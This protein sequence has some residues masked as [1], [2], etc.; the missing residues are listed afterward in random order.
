MAQ[1]VVPRGRTGRAVGVWWLAL[2]A[3]AF[4]V[5]APLPYLTDGLQAMASGDGGLAAHYAAQPTWVQVVL[6]VHMICSGTALLLSPVQL[7]SRVRRRTP[8]THRVVGR[9]TFGALVGGG[10]AGALL[11]PFSVAGALGTAGFGLLAVLSVVFP[12]LGL[13]SALRGDLAQHRRWMIR[14]F[15]LIYAGVMLRLGLIVVVASTGWDFDRAYLLMPFGSWV[16]NLLVAEFVLWRSS[17]RRAAR[18][19]RG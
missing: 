11:A 8:R 6:Y 16:P 15:A 19:P 2:T 9:I 17:A 4:A 13:R 3:G 1:A 10:T 18:L 5:Y 14:A 7:S 12:V